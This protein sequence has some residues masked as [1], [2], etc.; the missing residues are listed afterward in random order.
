MTLSVNNPAATAMWSALLANAI[1]R[2]CRMLDILPPSTLTPEEQAAN[3]QRWH[4]ARK[5]EAADLARLPAFLAALDALCR[6]HG[7]TIEARER[8]DALCDED[9]F[10]A[11]IGQARIETL[12]V[13]GLT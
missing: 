7:V 12:A 1:E 2:K 9:E 4:E 5:Q 3:L 8:T 11:Y 13:G 6:E 10:R